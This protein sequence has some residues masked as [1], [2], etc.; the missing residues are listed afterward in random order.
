[1]NSE[2]LLVRRKKG[3]KRYLV[4]GTVCGVFFV[5][6]VLIGYFSHPSTPSTN[7]GNKPDS[8]GPV[9]SGDDRQRTFSFFALDIKHGRFLLAH[10]NILCI[11]R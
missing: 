1:M 2:E 4:F 9:P 5:I 3:N 7:G 10:A 11:L 6:G 8:R